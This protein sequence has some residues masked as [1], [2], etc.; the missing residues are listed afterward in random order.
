MLRNKNNISREENSSVICYTIKIIYKEERITVT[1]NLRP[2]LTTETT[3]GSGLINLAERYKIVSGDEINI[4]TNDEQFA[5][6]IKVLK[7]EN[8][9]Y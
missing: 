7:N 5:V 1:N 3:T 4:H 2:K 6:S 8:S 9:N